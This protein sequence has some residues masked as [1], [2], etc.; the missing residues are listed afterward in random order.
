ML[1]G[2][3]NCDFAGNHSQKQP[4]VAC[5]LK[6][7]PFADHEADEILSVH[8]IEHFWRWEVRNVLKEWVRVLK[9]GGKLILEC[10][11]FHTAC[12]EFLRRVDHLGDTDGQRTMWV[13]YGDPG[14][15]DPHM[16][17]RWGYTPV[18]LGALMQDCG[19]VGV[20]QEPCEFKM[21]E[22]RDMRMVG[23]AA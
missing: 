9:P 22:P 18:T 3:V 15:Q 5:D 4:D 8:V 2:Y 19:L 21:K 14:W 10:P 20:K 1:P 11:N 16:V 13:F 12:V 7:L 17:H 23:W 6:A